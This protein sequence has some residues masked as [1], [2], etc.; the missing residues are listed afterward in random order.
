MDLQGKFQDPAVL[1]V[2]AVN[3]E[4]ANSRQNKPDKVECGRKSPFIL[5]PHCL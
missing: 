1:A 4:Y 5:N 2:S 3:L